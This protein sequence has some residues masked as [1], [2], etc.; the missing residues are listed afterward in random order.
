MEQSVNQFSNGM[1]LDYNPMLQ[2]NDSLSECLNGTIITMNG[3]E[4][5]LQNDMGNRRIDNAFLPSGYEPVGMKEYGGVIY[6]AAYN[7]ITKRSQIGSFPSPERRI[8][9][10]NTQGELNLNNFQTYSETINGTSYKFLKSDIQ[11]IPLTKDIYLHP[12]DKFIVWS[13]DT[14]ELNNNNI[15][16]WNNTNGSKI[17]SPKNKL[18]TLSVGIMNSQNEFVDITKN[19]VRW[20]DDGEIYEKEDKTDLFY[21]NEGYF[22]KRQQSNISMGTSI[23][24]ANLINERQTITA[25]TYSHKLIG[26]MYLKAEINHIQNFN[27][28]LIAE[29][30]GLITVESIIIYNCPDGIVTGGRTDEIYTTYSEGDIINFAFTFNRSSGTLLQGT[31]TYDTNTNLYT[32]KIVSQFQVNI[33]TNKILDYVLAVKSGLTENTQ[34]IYLRGLTVIGQIDFSLINSN[35]TNLTGWRYKKDGNS[36][37][38]D[39]IV[40]LYPSYGSSYSNLKLKFKNINDASDI[41]T[42]NVSTEIA[43]NGEV[44]ING[45]NITGLQEQQIYDVE[46]SVT[47]NNSSEVTLSTDK[48]IITTDLFNDC[49]N[50]HNEIL[51]FCDSSNSVIHELQEIKVDMNINSSDIR[52]TTDIKNGGSKLFSKNNNST[53]DFYADNINTIEL[54][55]NPEIQIKDS[56]KYPN[57]LGADGVG[58][59]NEYQLY[60]SELDGEEVNVT[61]IEQKY[62]DK[63]G[64]LHTSNDTNVSNKTFIEIS[65]EN[66]GNKIIG[67]IH[68][69]DRYL[70]KSKSGG[71]KE[72]NGAFRSFYN[73][74]DNTIPKISNFGGISVDSYNYVMYV[75]AINCNESKPGDREDGRNPDY[76]DGQTKPEERSS[77]KVKESIVLTSKN[78]NY[79]QAPYVYEEVKFEDV[80]EEFY[81]FLNDQM[82]NQVFTYAFKGEDEVITSTNSVEDDYANGYNGYDNAKVWWKTNDNKWAL[83][84]TSSTNAINHFHCTTLNTNSNFLNYLKSYTF[85]EDF[86]YK[87]H[88]SITC[89]QAGIYIPNPEKASYYE[90]DDY[91]IPV[92]VSFTYGINSADISGLDKISSKGFWTQ[93]NSGIPLLRKTETVELENHLKPSID[94]WEKV[95]SIQNNNLSLNNI[96]IDLATD[97]D[98]NFDK[99]DE[100]SFY[101]A[102]TQVNR[103]N[104]KITLPLSIQGTTTVDI[105]NDQIEYNNVVLKKS[106]EELF[107]PT[108]EMYKSRSSGWYSI[109]HFNKVIK[110]YNIT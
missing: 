55:I 49:Y 91:N 87:A 1:Q 14:G 63:L 98:D 60:I 59:I 16:N 96:N 62:K 15:S 101:L 26:P 93:N 74:L 79:T 109:L 102:G 56:S 40:G 71:T 48:W 84:G 51:D 86:Y 108:S 32:A 18:Y 61:N 8:S 37:L 7:P 76:A 58:G 69:Y 3:N 106:D 27:Y 45:I 6:V 80:S 50:N 11:L 90:N 28:T 12:G 23:N 73:Y 13:T 53:I 9:G 83:V 42:H 38:L 44:H 77:A 94:F 46:I 104:E 81:N 36:M 5:I 10:N 95:R 4:F 107:H 43:L 57:F 97:V 39:I 82:G 103:R 72:I 30:T 41:H 110:V 105:S 78:H 92:K 24:N 54:T 21:S 34:P 66:I 75:Y 2:G 47:E 99:L 70:T 33:P 22:I 19:M 85:K 52:E 25:N 35:T 29:S 67:T 31:T 100:Q 64:S 65:T 17:I 88:N 20:S 68:H 89:E